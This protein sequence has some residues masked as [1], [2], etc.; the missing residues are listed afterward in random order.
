MEKVKG[1]DTHKSISHNALTITDIQL[2]FISS[3]SVAP[4]EILSVKLR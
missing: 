1:N 4:W 2:L 3:L